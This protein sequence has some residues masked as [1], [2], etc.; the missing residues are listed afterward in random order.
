MGASASWN[1]R[2]SMGNGR[3]GPIL[4]LTTLYMCRKE[5]KFSHPVRK[6][7]ETDEEGKDKIGE[8]WR[9]SSLKYCYLSIDGASMGRCWI[10]PFDLYDATMWRNQQQL[11]PERHGDA[12]REE[13]KLVRGSDG[14]GAG[15]PLMI[16][17][18]EAT[19]RWIGKAVANHL[20]DREEYG[21]HRN[22]GI[23]IP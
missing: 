4:W 15:N 2:R 5:E 21:S 22:G 10:S 7:M 11:D 12:I 3:D 6:M 17:K 20:E 18:Q 8:A 1:L 14:W 16:V 13:S 9:C 23:L 19:N